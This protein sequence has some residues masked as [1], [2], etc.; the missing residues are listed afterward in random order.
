MQINVIKLN[1]TWQ[2]FVWSSV[3]WT[4]VGNIKLR[5]LKCLLYFLS[6][7]QH[8]DFLQ[9]LYSCIPGDPMALVRT[10]CNRWRF[11]LD[12][13]IEIEGEFC[14]FLV[15]AVDLTTDNLSI[16]NLLKIHWMSQKWEI[17]ILPIDVLPSGK[18]LSMFQNYTSSR[19]KLL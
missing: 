11:H 1:L 6:C 7:F 10:A 17:R 4:P 16:Q 3:I 14:L 19:I 13:I 8:C 5:Y 9:C 2:W 18:V 12:R 15:P